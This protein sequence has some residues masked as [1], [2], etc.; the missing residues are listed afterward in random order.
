MEKIFEDKEFHGDVSFF[1][2]V[3]IRI[4]A[5][6]TKALT[7]VGSLSLTGDLTMTGNLTITL[8]NAILT[9]GDLTMT[10][11]DLLISDGALTLTTGDITLTAGKVISDGGFVSSAVTLS[12]DDSV[13]SLNT[14]PVGVNTV[15]VND[16]ENDANDF[17]VLPNL[18]Q[19]EK[20]HV[21]TILC[22]AG[23]NFEIRCPSAG[24]NKINTVDCGSAGNEYLATDTEVIK[25]VARDATDGW[26]LTGTTALGAVAPAVIPDA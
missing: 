19:V 18:A 3:T 11:G 1:K 5:L 9:A 4:G 7:V 16:A 10:L 24:S 6:V 8:G 21:I 26:V 15:N 14:I 25:C 20:G 17:I 22:N 12:A 2:A 13:T 23:T